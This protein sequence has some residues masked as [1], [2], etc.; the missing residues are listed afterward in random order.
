[1]D[2]SDSD[3]KFS[4]RAMKKYNPGTDNSEWLT[5]SFYRK[6][7]LP[8]QS[9]SAEK[10]LKVFSEEIVTH[11]YSLGVLFFRKSMRPC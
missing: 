5:L 3:G 8:E 7:L 10:E 6:V 11:T 2:F 4:Q 1:M 9:F